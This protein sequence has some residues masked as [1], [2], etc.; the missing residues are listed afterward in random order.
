MW[1]A[2]WES[3]CPGRKGEGVGARAGRWA[4]LLAEVLVMFLLL[5]RQLLILAQS[6]PPPLP[7]SVLPLRIP[8]LSQ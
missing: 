6:G 2:I 4:I 3:R 1:D 7:L 8:R 5:C